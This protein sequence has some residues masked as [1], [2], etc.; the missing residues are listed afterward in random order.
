[1]RR[2]Y[3]EQN[4]INPG[5]EFNPCRLI[6][7]YNSNSVVNCFSGP[8]ATFYGAFNTPDLRLSFCVGSGILSLPSRALLKNPPAWS[9]ASYT[10]TEY[11]SCTNSW[12]A[13]NPA[14]PDPKIIIDCIF[15]PVYADT[16]SFAPMVTFVFKSRDIRQP[17]FASSASLA[18]NSGVAPGMMALTSR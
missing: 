13:L 10:V 3:G 5:E 17:V 16:I 4:V 15:T 8:S 18:N 2:F 11:P 12:A 1:M 6:L 7:V 14:M 9:V